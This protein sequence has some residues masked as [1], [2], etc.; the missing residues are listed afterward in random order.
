[1]HSRGPAD[2]L[3]TRMRSWDP[4]IEYLEEIPI[5]SAVM[6]VELILLSMRVRYAL[7]TLEWNDAEHVMEEVREFID[8]YS[9]SSP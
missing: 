3:I 2:D 4:V 7:E 9:G 6:A 8:R 5:E 1:M